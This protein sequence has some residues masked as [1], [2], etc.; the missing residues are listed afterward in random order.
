MDKKKDN[1]YI[2][3]RIKINKKKDIYIFIDT[4]LSIN[5]LF[6]SNSFSFYV[7]VYIL[8]LIIHFIL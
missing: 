4:N 3:T 2:Y 1:K 6:P 5:S 7:K 8:Y